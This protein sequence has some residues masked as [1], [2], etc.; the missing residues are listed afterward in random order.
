MYTYIQSHRNFITYLLDLQLVN[1]P[2]RATLHPDFNPDRW[3]D[4]AII[5]ELFMFGHNYEDIDDEDYIYN[6]CIF[7]TASWNPPNPI[8]DQAVIDLATQVAINDCTHVK[9]SITS[10]FR[11][12]LRARV[13]HRFPRRNQRRR[14]NPRGRQPHH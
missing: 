10:C 7:Y 13:V 9:E 8:T 4:Q 2:Q 6:Q 5:S 11:N 14:P 12:E 1:G 3:R